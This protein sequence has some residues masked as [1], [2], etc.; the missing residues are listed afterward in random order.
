MSPSDHGPKHSHRMKPPSPQIDPHRMRIY[1]SHVD[2]ARNWPKW[3]V[4][5]CFNNSGLV[6][7]STLSAL[8]F[9]RHGARC[10]VCARCSRPTLVLPVRD[11]RLPMFIIPRRVRAIALA[12]RR[13]SGAL[14]DTREACHILLS[15]LRKR[16][17][18]HYSRHRD[19]PHICV[20]EFGFPRESPAYI[21]PRIRMSTRTAP[22]S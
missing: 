6:V 7:T 3:S 10:S 14:G 22:T 17:P 16:R 5:N 1:V 18:E 20:S 19:L 8:K 12:A 4:C 2:R 11:N 13:R 15:K 9:Q 21:N